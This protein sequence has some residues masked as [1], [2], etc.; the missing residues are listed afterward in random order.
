M[1]AGRMITLFLR[2]GVLLAALAS[3]AAAQNSPDEDLTYT[4]SPQFGDGR[5]KVDIVWNTRGRQQSA[6]GVAPAF[7]R[8]DDV[9]GLIRDVA[10][11]GADRTRHDG[12]LWIMLHPK[13]ASLRITYTV[14]AGKRDFSDWND[15]HR[16]IAAAEF[17]HGIGNAFL[18]VPNSGDGVP[19][20]FQTMLRW[21]LPA[22][23]KALCSWGTTRAVGATM[24]PADLR[25]SVY[26]AG[27][28]TTRKV[29]A[30]GRTVTVAMPESFDFSIDDFAKFTS[31]VIGEQCRFMGEKAFPSF[32]VT[33]IPVGGKLREGDTRLAGS[34]LYNSFA[35]FVPPGAKIDD[36]VE[37]LFAHELFHYWN[38][39][40]L[41]ARQPE[42]LVYW[43][44]EGFTDYYALRILFESKRWNA[45]TYA[46]WLNKHLREYA[47]NPAATARNEEINS[48]YWSDRD[49]V[50][51][52]AYQRGLAL[53]LRWHKLARQKG[54]ADGVDKL[55]MHLVNRGRAE[56]FQVGN[57]EVRA[58]G[59]K[60]LGP[61]FGD[62]FDIYVTRA[63]VVPI[64]PD[65]LAPDLKGVMREH[66]DF[67]LGFDRAKTLRDKKVHG[68]V[69]ASAATA[70]G[71]RDGD[72][73]AG[74]TIPPNADQDVVL[75]V[76]RGGETKEIRYQP[77]GVKRSV[78]QFEPAD[79]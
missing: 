25:Q 46:K 35:L 67:Q 12:A 29:E 60:L 70:A 71:V 22:G 17:F 68:L 41:G 37:H 54:V 59:V 45:A 34:G 32:V 3:M 10:I 26:L 61:W 52:V 66:Y 6:L 14:A 5:I 50:G 75:Q 23:Y 8:I 36:A 40:V 9:P 16:P 62:E 38:G 43:F 33:A 15:A 48:R 13:N 39:R 44:V 56:G 4:L 20:Q 77:R 65:V 64:A 79:R 21:Q 63:N 31:E 24:T 72:E 74:W 1:F 58:A 47:A 78:L 30:E 51:Q 42:R 19:G 18:M 7:G 2:T 69:P 76:K 11:T 57:D 55:F 27:K 28:L 53:G 49:T 73:L